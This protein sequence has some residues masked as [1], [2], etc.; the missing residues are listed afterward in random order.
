MTIEQTILA[1]IRKA[2]FD[3]GF[4]EKGDKILVG[5]SG[6]KDSMALVHVLNT[7]KKFRDKDFD[8]VAVYLDL[9]FEND[10]IDEMKAYMK[11]IGVNFIVYDATTVAPILRQHMSKGLLPCSICSRMKKAC[12]NKAAHELGITK[13]S[14]AHHADDAIETLFMNMTYGGRV[15]TFAP[16]MFLS[17]EKITFIRPLIYAREKDIEEYVKF[18]NIPTFKNTCGNDKHTK[19]EDFKTLLNGIYKQ[20]DEA[21]GN[22]LTMLTNVSKFDLW[23]DDQAFY[24]GD[25]YSV[26]EVLTKEEMLE[27]FKIR[28]KVFIEEQNI[29]YED[30]FDFIDDESR[31]FLLRKDEKPIGTMRILGGFDKIKM[32]RLCILKEYRN[33]NLGSRFI[34]YVE[35]IFSSIHCPLRVELDAQVRAKEFYLKNGFK[36]EGE[37]FLDAGIP[38]VKMVKDILKPVT[39]STK[40]PF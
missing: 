3:F 4:I 24:F 14:F 37:E 22:Y 5:L 9:G 13:V 10:S 7:Y 15:A 33:K 12:I 30:E 2:D 21:K 38:H 17:N 26:K 23:F 40:N 19:R 11:S 31:T 8:F 36:E 28:K 29:S 1:C 39:S 35:K 34:R 27:S 20:F 6:G 18:F 16:K 32:T 25:S